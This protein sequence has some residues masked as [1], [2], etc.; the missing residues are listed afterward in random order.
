MGR[1]DEDPPK[2]YKEESIMT[3]T[4]YTLPVCPNCNELKSKLDELG[5]HYLTENLE[6][7]ESKTKLLMNGVFTSV[8]P[9]LQVDKKFYTYDSFFIRDLLDEDELKKLVFEE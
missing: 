6:T 1:P 9:I 3:V 5:V 4:V 8:A 2:V 7:P